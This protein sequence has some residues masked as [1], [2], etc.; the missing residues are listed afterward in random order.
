MRILIENPGFLPKIGG[1]E[2]SLDSIS[3]ELEKKGHTVY[4]FTKRLFEEQ[5]EVERYG[6]NIIVIRYDC[7]HNR[8][9]PF[10]PLKHFFTTYLV[11]R[12]IFK[13]KKIDIV[14]S[15]NVT[16]ALS[17]IISKI[18]KNNIFVPPAL[19]IL[20]MVKPSIEFTIKENIF[21]L[22]ALTKYYQRYIFEK[23]VFENIEKINVFS[24]T[25]KRQ[26][27]ENYKVKSSIK[28]NRP[29]IKKDKFQEK[30]DKK[31]ICE[32]YDIPFN[33]K[34]LLYLGR[35]SKVKNV[36]LLINAYDKIKETDTVLIIVGDGDDY[37]YCKELVKKKGLKSEVMFLGKRLNQEDFYSIAD[38]TIVPSF[39]EPFGQ[40]ITE[41]LSCGTPV[42]GFKNNNDTVQVAFDEIVTDGQEGFVV[43]EPTQDKLEQK[44]DLAI[45]FLERK[46]EYLAM[47]DN[48]KK[49]AKDFSWKKFVKNILKE[50][51]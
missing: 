26:V 18:S 28:I 21:L 19:A 16:L 49:R 29:G 5:K 25:M 40:V 50:F 44:L 34:K 51:I 33:K 22:G 48:C 6:K 36:R 42:I 11:K 12:N 45:S 27:E 8:Y 24:Q 3:R 41:S 47:K 17:S 20:Q 46:E 15:R 23:I 14:I 37:E 39:Y 10:Y 1:I 43:D 7:S 31:A 2:T 35:V 4:I 9:N 30:N 32:E 38:F 13:R